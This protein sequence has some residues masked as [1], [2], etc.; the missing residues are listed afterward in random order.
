MTMG[1]AIWDRYQRYRGGRLGGTADAGG[2]VRQTCWRTRGRRVRTSSN[3]SDRL[4]SPSR[5]KPKR[6]DR[7]G[8]T[9]HFATKRI[10]STTTTTWQRS[11]G[12]VPSAQ[13]TSGHPR[14]LE[15]SD[16]SS[17]P[18][19]WVD[20]IIRV[21]RDWTDSAE[22]CGSS[23]L[24]ASTGPPLLSAKSRI[25]CRANRRP[26]ELTLAL[27]CGPYDEFGRDSSGKSWSQSPRNS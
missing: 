11:S 9:R 24:P 16:G 27:R 2:R 12:G 14:G 3:S 6:L 25:D 21:R 26:P 5:R 1:L 15:R 19:L 7:H 22:S 17:S 4:A 23:A 20:D 18:S 13:R 8:W 10:E